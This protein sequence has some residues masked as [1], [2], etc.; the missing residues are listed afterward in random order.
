MLSRG[1]LRIKNPEN[2]YDKASVEGRSLAFGSCRNQNNL[3][4]ITDV[5]TRPAYVDRL[6]ICLDNALLSST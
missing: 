3:N 2:G 5:D 1:V 6:Q 4:E